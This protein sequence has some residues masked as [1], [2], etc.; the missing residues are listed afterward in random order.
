MTGVALGGSGLILGPRPGGGSLAPFDPATEIAPEFWWL[1]EPA[2]CV[3]SGGLVDRLVNAG[4]GGATADFE[5]VGAARAPLATD[6]DG[7]T[8]LAL[9][10]V[11]DYY[12]SVAAGALWQFLCDGPFT[13]FVVL[14]RTSPGPGGGEAILDLING[15]TAG[16]GILLAWAVAA[17]PE[18][19]SYGPFCTICQAN[20]GTA[21]A[22]AYSTA[23]RLV[24]KEVWSIGYGGR[25]GVPGPAAQAHSIDLW[26]RRLGSP[27]A[28]SQ[29]GAI[30]ANGAGVSNKLSLGRYTTVASSFTNSRIYEILIVPRL[31]SDR[32]VF[33]FEDY[34]RLKYEIST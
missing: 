16:A 3:E 24:Q 26:V 30:L 18:S 17:N 11:A 20:P 28:F 23:P 31:L 22:T 4:S 1:A 27:V 13:I 21:I 10:G 29:R 32:L 2:H 33:G 7:N 8:Y 14:Q 9:D 19:G 5:Q 25:D 34:A 15:A 12:Q 6:G